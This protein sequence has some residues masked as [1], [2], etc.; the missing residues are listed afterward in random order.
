MLLFHVI[1]NHTSI[2]PSGIG[3]MLKTKINVNL[4]ISRDCKDMD[5]EIEKVNNA[6]KMGAESIMD[7]SSYGDTRTF[8]KRLT[9]ECPAIIGTV[10]IYDAVVYYHKALKDITAKEMV[11]YC[12]NACRRW[13]GFHDYSLWNQ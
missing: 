4:G 2:D 11:R 8:R 12:K 1:K 7:L 5:V 6:V 13:C 9:K 10:P 3:S